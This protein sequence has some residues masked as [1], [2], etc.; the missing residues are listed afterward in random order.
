MDI[1]FHLEVVISKMLQIFYFAIL[2]R[3]LDVSLAIDVA[4]Q[5]VIKITVDLV[6]LG[7][8]VNSS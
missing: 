2:C 6:N 4:V 8:G 3:I 7:G 1:F 5:L